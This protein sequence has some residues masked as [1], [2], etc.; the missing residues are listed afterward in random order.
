MPNDWLP[1][2][3]HGEFEL[4]DFLYHKEQM[5]TGKM[6]ELCLLM[7]SIYRDHDPP[8]KAHAKLYKTID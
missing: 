3:S 4:A 8:L 2:E 6:N 5:S 7:A 1:F